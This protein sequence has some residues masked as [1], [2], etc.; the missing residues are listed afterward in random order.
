MTDRTADAQVCPVCHELYEGDLSS[1]EAHV[2]AH[3]DNESN[4]ANEEDS[5]KSHDL[6]DLNT[7]SVECEAEGCGEIGR[8]VVHVSRRVADY[9]KY[10]NA[11]TKWHPTHS[12]SR[13]YGRAHG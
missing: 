5:S 12:Q 11:N 13:R 4:P 1:F 8:R 6:L 3:F 2:D 10:Q 9:F 7:F